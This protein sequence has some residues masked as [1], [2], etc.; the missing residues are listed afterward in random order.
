MAGCLVVTLVEKLSMLI[1]VACQD[2]EL[3]ESVELYLE[4]VPKMAGTQW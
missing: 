2:L 3:I 1:A 4:D